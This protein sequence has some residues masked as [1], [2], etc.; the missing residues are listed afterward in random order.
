MIAAVNGR[1]DQSANLSVTSRVEV[2]KLDRTEAAGI[3]RHLS[4]LKLLSSRK[5]RLPRNTFLLYSLIQLH[6]QRCPT[7][8]SWNAMS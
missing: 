4:D 1:T 5:E 3:F 2:P 8:L 7:R 6:V